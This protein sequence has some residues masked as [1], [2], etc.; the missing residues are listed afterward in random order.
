M[1]SS[2]KP[3]V[4]ILVVV[5]V[6]SLVGLLCYRRYTGLNR[7]QSALLGNLAILFP[8]GWLIYL[9]GHQGHHGIG[10]E[11]YIRTKVGPGMVA[12]VLGF[13]LLLFPFAVRLGRK[14]FGN[15]LTDAE[16]QPGL[17]GVRAWLAPG[18]LLCATLISL[19]AWQWL[20]LPLFVLLA[21]TY[22][23][24]LAYPLY[25]LAVAVGADSTRRT[26][27]C[28]REQEQVQQLLLAGKI[29]EAERVNLLNVMGCS[30]LTEAPVQGLPRRHRRILLGILSV[31]LAVLTGYAGYVY[32]D[33]KYRQRIHVSA[34]A[35]LQNFGNIELS[36]GAP[37]N[38]E[39]GP[40][41]NVT[42]IATPVTNQSLLA[43]RPAAWSNGVLQMTLSYTSRLVAA[44]GKV[45]G[46]KTEQQTCMYPQSRLLAV[47][48]DRETQYP[49]AVTMRPKLMSQPGASVD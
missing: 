2:Y 5:A 19:F 13:S 38:F 28:V 17:A 45:S 48:F 10:T 12:S 44:E 23:L 9:E 20:S 8:L 39:L 24:V 26:D 27:N 21:A 31:G 18:N 32:Q 7:W 47:E 41:K 40:G 15:R 6:S 30:E 4:G 29:T 43:N 33:A 11:D 36:A 49:I 14:L 16:K 46:L 1:N 37:R 25:H 35:K 42:V 22:G 3:V 34:K